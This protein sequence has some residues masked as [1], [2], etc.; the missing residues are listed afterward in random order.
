MR[1]LRGAAEAKPIAGGV[2]LNYVHHGLT[3]VEVAGGGRPLLVMIA[4]RRASDRI[5]RQDMAGGTVLMIG[6]HLLRSARLEGHVLSL[7]GDTGTDGAARIFAPAISGL[8]WMV[9]K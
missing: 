9:G 8:T 7:T 3:E 5:W 1:V 6:S 4:D 2:Q